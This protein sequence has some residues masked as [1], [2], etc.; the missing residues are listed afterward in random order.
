[1]N[2]LT[3]IP[4][5][6]TA[7]CMLLVAAAAPVCADS[8]LF[9]FKERTP[10][11]VAPDGRTVECVRYASDTP[12]HYEYLCL[13]AFAESASNPPQTLYGGE[14]VNLF[15][16]EGMKT[17][18]GETGPLY[19]SFWFHAARGLN[20]LCYHYFSPDGRF[21][22]VY[23][24][25]QGSVYTGE[26]GT[27]GEKR[28]YWDG[29]SYVLAETLITDAT[30]QAIREVER[31]LVRVEIPEVMAALRK[32]G[33]LGGR[34][35]SMFDYPPERVILPLW[36][37]FRYH[38]AGLSDFLDAA[39]Y[40]GSQYRSQPSLEGFLAFSATVPGVRAH[41][42]ACGLLLE[43]QNDAEKAATLRRFMETGE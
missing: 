2:L 1:M 32:L 34:D 29:E 23:E 4:A 5:V 9:A 24:R 38:P 40:A 19:P 16:V 41:I 30:E 14:G 12:E 18:N 15:Y 36:H 37:F 35:G 11:G 42:A 39:V 13:L 26:G 6:A 10:I 7:V 3:R 20:G 43:K 25:T 21:V 8:P 33:D 27:I 28:F 22:Y 17:Q 31:A